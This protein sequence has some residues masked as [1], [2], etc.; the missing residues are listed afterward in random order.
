M[1]Y[2][3]NPD[4]KGFH[5]DTPFEKDELPPNPLD[6]FCLDKYQGIDKSYK[7]PFRKDQSLNLSATKRKKSIR[8]S[9]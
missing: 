7:R 9:P 3:F 2:Y 6:H 4:N 1:M 8:K 5:V